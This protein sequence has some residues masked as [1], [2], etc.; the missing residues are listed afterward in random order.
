MKYIQLFVPL[1]FFLD[2]SHNT[3]RTIRGH[4][5]KN[6]THIKMQ[7]NLHPPNKSTNFYL[8]Q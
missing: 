6:Y 3:S 7:T 2:S 8:I 1:N 5:L 4:R